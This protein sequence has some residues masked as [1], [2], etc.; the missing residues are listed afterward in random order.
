MAGMCSSRFVE[1]PNAAC[2]AIALRMLAGGENVACVVSAASVQ[3]EQRL[4]GPDGHV[5]PDRLAG[6]RQ[7]RVG[8]RQPERLAHDLRRRRRAEELAAAARRGAGAAAEIGG[9]LQAR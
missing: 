6:R 3:I 1:P 8:Q 5:E 2:T 9:V 7:R 4:R